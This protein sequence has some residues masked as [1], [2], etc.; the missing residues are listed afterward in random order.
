MVYRSHFSTCALKKI[1]AI[2]VICTANDILFKQDDN[3]LISGSRGFIVSA[4]FLKKAELCPPSFPLPFLLSTCFAG[5]N[6]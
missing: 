4:E 6:I 2:K 1:P 5:E 3:L